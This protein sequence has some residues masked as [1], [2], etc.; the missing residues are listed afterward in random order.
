MRFEIASLEILVLEATA[1][2]RYIRVGERR[3]RAR[4]VSQ[5]RPERQNLVRALIGRT[6]AAAPVE[7]SDTAIRERLLAELKAQSWAPTVDVSVEGG[8][9]KLA[10]AIFDDRQR[11]AIRVAAENIPGVKSVE[12]QLAWIEPT[13]GMVIE[14]RAA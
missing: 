3:L 10:G 6:S 4:H 7:S 12:D 14:P 11:D 13:S 2:L 9:V 5:A 8:R 1:R